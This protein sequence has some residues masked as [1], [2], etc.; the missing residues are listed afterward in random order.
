MANNGKFLNMVNGV[1][2][3]VSAIATS[4]G[5]SDANKILRTDAAG[6]I[7][8][9]FMPNGIGSDAKT[10]M[11]SEALAANDV[12]N[13]WLDAGVVKMRK[14]DATA[15]GKEADGFVLAAVA[16]GANGTCYFNGTISGLSGLTLAAYYYLSAATPG[17]IVTAAP[18]AA[19]NVAQRVG[20]ALSAT[21]LE[22]ERGTPVTVA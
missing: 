4:A 6:K 16:S 20:K 2:R 10:V 1:L 21:E 19:N 11:A 22:F 12:V 17:A 13:L 5:A 3:Q 7:D 18:S 14:A 9:T 15:E 8:M